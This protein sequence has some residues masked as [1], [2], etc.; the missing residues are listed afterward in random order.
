MRDVVA[1][2]IEEA[3]LLGSSKYGALPPAVAGG[4]SED[5]AQAEGVVVVVI[6]VT[7]LADTI[8]ARPE[9]KARRVV[10]LLL[11]LLLLVDLVLR[12]RHVVVVV[13]SFAVDCMGVTESAETETVVA[14][15]T[16]DTTDTSR[17]VVVQRRQFFMIFIK[18]KFEQ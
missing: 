16:A 1:G 4:T 10:R 15:R 17:R 2:L 7:T 12:E 11:L 14:S 13:V 8:V 5:N 9:T 3:R 18:T 6:V